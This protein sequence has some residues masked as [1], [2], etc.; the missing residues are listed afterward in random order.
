LTAVYEENGRLV[1]V[2]HRELNPDN[3][4]SQTADDINVVLAIKALGADCASDEVKD[5]IGVA[6]IDIQTFGTFTRDLVSV[7]T[8]YP[9][10]Y[11]VQDPKNKSLYVAKLSD[12]KTKCAVDL[13]MKYKLVEGRSYPTD[14]ILRAAYV[15]MLYVKNNRKQLDATEKRVVVNNSVLMEHANRAVA[16]KAQ[17]TISVENGKIKRTG[18]L[19]EHDQDTRYN[20]AKCHAVAES[21]G[22]GYMPN[23]NKK[24]YVP[25]T[26]KGKIATHH[27]IDGLIKET[28]NKNE[29][30]SKAVRLDHKAAL[31]QVNP[32]LDHTNGKAIDRLRSMRLDE[33]ISRLRTM[34]AIDNIALK[35]DGK[36]SLVVSNGTGN[37]SLLVA[38]LYCGEHADILAKHV[39]VLSIDQSTIEKEN[40]AKIEKLNTSVTI[41]EYHGY[42]TSYLRDYRNLDP[43]YQVDLSE[44]LLISDAALSSSDV[45]KATK[46]NI[47]KT[48][49]YS[50]FA[51]SGIDLESLTYQGSLHH[52][53][54]KVAK[55]ARFFMFKWMIPDS[56]P[57]FDHHVAAAD[58]AAS[59]FYDLGSLYSDRGFHLAYPY[60]FHEPE[61]YVCSTMDGA[62]YNPVGDKLIDRIYVGEGP[63]RKVVGLTPMDAVISAIKDVWLSIDS[64]NTIRNHQ[65]QVEGKAGSRLGCLDIGHPVYEYLIKER[66]SHTRKLVAAHHKALRV[67]YVAASQDT[68]DRVFSASPVVVYNVPEIDF[69]E[70]LDVDVFEE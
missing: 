7:Q 18:V 2:P 14:P 17:R 13:R 6:D 40:I 56:L 22:A 44:A 1:L 25:E 65:V 50:D 30:R 49:N 33:Q 27:D 4:N 67:A 26:A 47:K 63:N 66:E 11:F 5:V 51:G 3:V 16:V 52:S 35:C 20:G 64:A 36:I 58:I 48:G 34:S 69:E 39:T 24:I 29:T 31:A 32:I 37:G 61:V 21:F 41:V 54:I 53:L 28:S 38:A 46:L 70:E 9:W 68:F 59:N 8:Q 60:R 19:V 43:K 15:K 12:P 45:A 10:F 57:A 23:K 55:Q 42:L 62:K